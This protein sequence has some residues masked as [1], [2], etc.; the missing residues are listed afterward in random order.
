MGKDV[1]AVA[2][3]VIALRER[4]S[5]WGAATFRHWRPRIKRP[6]FAAGALN[7]AHYLAFR[8]SDLRPLQRELMP[9]G[10]SSLGRAEGRVLASLD[11]VAS[12]MTR[13][14][15]SPRQNSMRVPTSRQF[16]R[17]ERRLAAETARIFG[18]ARIGR[19]GHI[20]ATLGTDAARDPG[21]VRRI[22][23]CGAD[24]VRINCAHDDADRWA[25]MVE[26]VRVAEKATGRRIRILIDIAGPKV[27]TTQVAAPD[28]PDR[29]GVGDEI[30]IRRSGALS[31]SAIPFSLGCSLPEVLERVQVGDRMALDDG[32]VTG[33]I[34]REAHGN[35]VAK[36]ETA[37]IKGYRL[38]P[39]KG[40]NF[41]GVALGLAPLTSKDLED[42][43]F[44]AHNADLLGFS[45]VHNGDDIAR[46]QHELAMRRSTWAQ[47][48]LVPKIETAAAIRNL[49]GIIIQA[50][51]RQPVA[52]MIARGDLAVEIGFERLAET[53]EEI[54]W[55]CE[56]AHVPVIWAT[57][58]LEGLVKKGVPSRGEMTDAAM[59]ARAECIMLNK[60]P[61]QLA[62][63]EALDAIMRRMSESQTKKSSLLPALH[64]WVA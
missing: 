25:R 38:K 7:L 13:I 5:T 47:I 57:Q 52:V 41:P 35:L 24:A 18:P 23:E 21:I 55:L 36:I 37:P 50:G 45:F 48:A 61:N 20:L 63:V 22:V 4:V 34:V 39:D 14:S 29:V 53:Q 43:D 31:D 6:H 56:A 9:L 2:D 33:R 58:V 59:A 15:S 27:R 19:A 16:F 62:G 51:G 10:I 44:V 1:R 26:H 64:A 49:P 17:G 46:L 42:L 54:L 32:K 30:L 12:T 11:A 40:L 28:Y 3:E 8:K 60:G